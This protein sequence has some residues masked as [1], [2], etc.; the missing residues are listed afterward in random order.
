MDGRGGKGAQVAAYSTGEKA[1]GEKQ[2]EEME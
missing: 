2:Q 1:N